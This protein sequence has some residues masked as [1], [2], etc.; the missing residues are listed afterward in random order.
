MCVWCV[1]VCVR[2]RVC[3]CV[4]VYVVGGGEGG[5]G[6]E[7]GGGG[8]GGHTPLGIHME[9]HHARHTVWE[10]RSKKRVTHRLVLEVLIQKV[11]ISRVLI[12]NQMACG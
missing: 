3:V 12:Q 11:C 10:P 4:C 7:G 1:C 8:Q 2:V 9:L 5:E 6:T